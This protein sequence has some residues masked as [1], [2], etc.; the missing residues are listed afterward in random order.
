[1]LESRYTAARSADQDELLLEDVKAFLASHLV[2]VD[3]AFVQS[4]M[5]KFDANGNGMLSLDEFQALVLQVVPAVLD[6]AE[7]CDAT[8]AA[9]SKAMGD[10]W[11]PRKPALPRP[12]SFRDMSQNE[13]RIL[14]GGCVCWCLALIA[15][16]FS[17][18]SILMEDDCVE[19]PPVESCT[20]PVSFEFISDVSPAVDIVFIADRSGSMAAFE[21]NNAGNFREFVSS[22]ASNSSAVANRWRLI[23]ANSDD[24]CH[25]NDGQYLSTNTPGVVEAFQRAA[26]SWRGMLYPHTE[27]LMVVAQKAIEADRPRG[28]NEGFLRR[29][30]LL[31]I[32]LVSDA[33]TPYEPMLEALVDRKGNDKSLVKVSVFRS[34]THVSF[35]Y[36]FTAAGLNISVDE[37][38]QLGAIEDEP[39]FGYAQA[40]N[41]TEGVD[42]DVSTNWRHA[43]YKRTGDEFTP[44]LQDCSQGYAIDNSLCSEARVQTE[45]LLCP[46]VVATVGTCKQ[47]V[48]GVVLPPAQV[49]NDGVC[50]LDLSGSGGDEGYQSGPVP[51]GRGGFS[52]DIEFSSYY[53]KDQLIV[54]NGQ[55]PVETRTDIES[56]LVCDDNVETDC[57]IYTTGCVGVTS[58]HS[59]V[60]FELLQDDLSIEIQVLPNCEGGRDTFWDLQSECTPTPPP[61]PAT[62]VFSPARPTC[63]DTPKCDT[64]RTSPIVR[65][66][67]DSDG[68]DSPVATE[69]CY[70]DLV[71]ELAVD[72][73]V[74]GHYAVPKLPSY[75]NYTNLQ[76][77]VGST[78]MPG[79]RVLADGSINPTCTG[80]ERCKWTLQNPTHR[81]AEARLE[82]EA[83][84]EELT[85]LFAGGQN[86]IRLQWD[87]SKLDGCATIHTTPCPEDHNL[88]LY[89]LFL[90]LLILICFVMYKSTSRKHADTPAGSHL[91]HVKD[92]A[93]QIHEVEITETMSISDVKS[94]LEKMSG[95]PLEEIRLFNEGYSQ[96][97]LHG[98]LLCS[99]CELIA[100]RG[101][102]P[103]VLTMMISWTIYVRE[104]PLSPALAA[105]MQGLGIGLAA[106]VHTV[107]GVEKHWKVESVKREHDSFALVQSMHFIFLH[108]AA[109]Q[110]E[111]MHRRV[112]ICCNITQFALSR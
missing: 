61:P 22:L 38:G 106:K 108:L 105:K 54:C 67:L 19:M 33:Q 2:D 17:I 26:S 25:T 94:L 20:D 66:G 39:G 10:E 58:Q 7:A 73:K 64:G 83:Q 50:S 102:P 77:Y 53:K 16:V 70:R 43:C 49:P 107:E 5:N 98:T 18:V 27:A 11:K 31:H 48:D 99:E 59:Y 32:I 3:D 23:V 100:E 1:M 35:P 93:G 21:E 103:K 76:L 109:I 97:E 88:L 30:A 6:R 24:G 91:I 13:Q 55:C 40:A 44:V 62:P 63:E 68:P 85:Q 75:Q 28:C 34:Y 42:G 92:F 79:P 101:S 78:R 41:E 52:L 46:Q 56:A 71:Q 84:Q 15:V 60:D 51:A 8:P 57:V 14:L 12:A 87:Q 86:V 74:F 37:F 89:A 47:A 80:A 45:P 112:A 96:E 29:D 9:D 111:I 110:N 104:E 81:A 82:F 65:D 72:R 90:L 36:Q 69:A 4:C 95:V